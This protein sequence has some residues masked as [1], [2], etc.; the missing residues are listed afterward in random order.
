MLA[1][2]VAGAAILPLAGARGERTSVNAAAH[3]PQP[4]AAADLTPRQLAGQRIVCGF[5]GRSAPGSLLRVI[6][7]GELAGVILF[8]DNVGSK[9]AVQRLTGAIQATDRPA[10]LR[11]PVL[12]SIDQEGGL[13]K[14]LPG[15]PKMSA[16]EMGSRGVA[17]ARSQGAA[18][19]ASLSSYGV[20]V[21][22]AP[23]GLGRRGL[24][25]G[26]RVRGDRGDGKALPGPGLH[27]GQHR[28]APGHD[29]AVREDTAPCRHRAVRELR[30]CWWRPGDGRLGALPRPG[31]GQA[32]RLPVKVR[33]EP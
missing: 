25:R 13:V 26:P 8:D 7:A 30:R 28:P 15:P 18:T 3:P 11:Q 14:R 12:I 29:P 20:N 23:G 6:A 5:D 19:G 32:P 16:A 24:R 31:Y 33:D 22:L 4:L 21:D 27:L 17:T 1:L 2:C 10:G 9:A